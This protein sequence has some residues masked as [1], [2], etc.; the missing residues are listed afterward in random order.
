MR[1]AHRRET[2][3]AVVPLRESRTIGRQPRGRIA[4]VEVP[5]GDRL[6]SPQVLRIA[7]LCMQKRVGMGKA[8]AGE[9]E[10]ATLAPIV[11]AVVQSCRWINQVV[12]P[13]SF[14]R[15]PHPLRMH[16][17]HRIPLGTKHENFV[18]TI[19]IAVSG[20][21]FLVAVPVNMCAPGRHPVEIDLARIDRLVAVVEKVAD[22]V[23]SGIC[24]LLFARL[25]GE[26]GE[27]LEQVLVVPQ[28]TAPFA[29][30]VHPSFQA[31]QRIGRHRLRWRAQRVG[32]EHGHEQ[33]G[34]FRAVRV[35]AVRDQRVEALTHQAAIVIGRRG[36]RDLAPRR[37]RDAEVGGQLEVER[38]GHRRL[39]D[40]KPERLVHVIL[41]AELVSLFDP[42][43]DHFKDSGD[44]VAVV[45]GPRN[46]VHSAYE[47]PLDHLRKSL[48]HGD[49]PQRLLQLRQPLG[50]RFRSPPLQLGELRVIVVD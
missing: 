23:C 41:L 21:S 11:V 39:G 30:A 42:R 1:P 48:G 46:D 47:L 25:L 36:R 18:R 10:V 5:A 14:D 3:V 24:I 35:P 13:D 15:S 45:L 6:G 44:R 12:L 19:P 4:M 20:R 34:V 31:D 28:I 38:H 33:G 17:V 8:A 2:V 7:G 37:E 43:A 29:A 16:A 50:L 40:R 49:Q 27:R 32:V 26:P 22:V 9:R